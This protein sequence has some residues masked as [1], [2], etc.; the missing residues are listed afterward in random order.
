[1]FRTAIISDYGD[2]FPIIG[3]DSI[4]LTPTDLNETRV[5]FLYATTKAPLNPFKD[6]FTL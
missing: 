3:S 1:M 6:I 2:Y 4:G 5:P